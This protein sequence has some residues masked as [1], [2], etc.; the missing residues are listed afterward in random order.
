MVTFKGITTVAL[1]L[2]APAISAV[3]TSEG[4]LHSQSL[5]MDPVG[6]MDDI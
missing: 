6:A 2:L 3:Q 4:Q 5:K 1:A